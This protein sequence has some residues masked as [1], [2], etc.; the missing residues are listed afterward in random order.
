MHVRTKQCQLKKTSRSYV[1]VTD[2]IIILPAEAFTWRNGDR[3]TATMKERIYSSSW[4][5]T[6]SRKMLSIASYV[7]KKSL[8][9]IV[10]KATRMNYVD[11]ISGIK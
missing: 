10:N 4:L 3:A 11:S 5:T 7:S 1:N 8:A 2:S 9:F 6:A